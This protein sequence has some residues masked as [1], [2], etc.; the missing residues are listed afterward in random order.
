MVRFQSRKID[1]S[2][3]VFTLSQMMAGKKLLLLAPGKSLLRIG[4][5]V[6]SRIGK[7][8]SVCYHH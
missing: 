7:I 5:T 3:S 2:E 6:C 1:D 8:K 4:G